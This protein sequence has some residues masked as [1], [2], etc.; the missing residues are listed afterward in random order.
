MAGDRCRGG[1]G[2]RD[3]RGGI[4]G[5]T[6]APAP[7]RGVGRRVECALLLSRAAGGGREGSVGGSSWSRWGRREAASH[8]EAS[9]LEREIQLGMGSISFFLSPTFSFFCVCLI[10]IQNHQNGLERSASPSPFI[11][12]V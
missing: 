3:R 5:R 1:V 4:E 7:A 12:R 6:R 11:L 9:P 2:S 10:K 8:C